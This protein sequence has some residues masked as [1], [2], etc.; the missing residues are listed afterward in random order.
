VA[1]KGRLRILET[2]QR[3][4]RKEKE[5]KWRKRRTTQIHVAL[6]SHR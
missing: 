3:L 6:N 1:K 2:G 4:Q 5:G